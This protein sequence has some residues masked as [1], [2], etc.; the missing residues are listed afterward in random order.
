MTIAVC[1]FVT[2]F[3][4]LFT[5]RYFYRAFP[6]AAIDFKIT[7]QQSRDIAENFL[8]KMGVETAGYRHAVKFDYQADAKTFLERTLPADSAN[9]L[10]REQVRIWRWS[11]RWFKPL[12]KQESTVRVSPDG[13][14]NGF[15]FQIPEAAPGAAVSEDSARCVAEKFL[16][17]TMGTQPTGLDFLS[18]SSQ[19]RPN[20]VDH[21][22]EWKKKDFDVHG[23]TLR[24]SVSVWGARIGAFSRYLHVP[25]KWQRDYAKLRAK[26]ET[27]GHIS[28]FFL[29]LTLIAMLVFAVQYTRYG[30]I[31]WKTALGFGIV[32][33]VLTFLSYMND[34]PLE[35]YDFPTTE[36]LNSFIVR[37]VLL[38]LVFSLLAGFSIFLLTAAA[39]PVYRERYGRH[40]SLSRLFTWK[41]LRT[42][43][44]FL[45]VIVG[46]ALTFFFA[47]YQVGFYILT[48]RSGG[49]APQDIP[50]DNMLNTAFPWIYV[51]LAGFMPAVSE[52]FISRMFSIP[53][54]EKFLKSRWPAVVIPAMIWGFA[55]ANYP[56][57]PFYIRGLEVGLAG[58]LIGFVMIRFGIWAAL[59]WH[60]TVD[61]LYTSFVLFRSGNPY[62]IITAA[63]SC[64]LLLV[65]L[66]L[67]LVFY[68]R[69]KNFVSEKGLTNSSESRTQPLPETPP[70]RTGPDL[71]EY[72]PLSRKKT[73]LAVVLVLALCVPFFISFEKIGGFVKYPHSSK[74]AAAAADSLLGD[75]GY[76][77]SGFQRVTFTSERLN[78]FAAIYALKFKSIERFNRLFSEHC[79][80]FRWGVRYFKSLETEE[81]LVY[82][83]PRDLGLVSFVRRIREDVPGAH[84]SQDSALA[85]AARFA[86]GRGINVSGMV[87]KEASSEKR[88]ARTDYTFEWQAPK[89]DVRNIGDMTYR[90]RID[91]QGRDVSTFTT[92]PH[93][94]EEWQRDRQK[95][96]LLNTAHL[97]LLIL[98]VG[99]FF[100]FALLRFIGR[101]RAGQIDWKK[102]LLVVLVVAGLYVIDSLTQ[103]NLAL[104]NYPTSIDLYLYRIVVIIGILIS[105]IV[106]AVAA[107]MATGLVSAFY[108][109][110]LSFYK[111]TSRKIYGRDAVLAAVIGVAGFAGTSRLND[112]VSSLFPQHVLF[113]SLSVPSKIAVPFPWFSA[114]A[115]TVF[116]GV[117][118]AGLPAFLVFVFGKTRNIYR[119][120]F[121]G[122]ALVAFLPL[123]I[124]T[125][126]EAV[127]ALGLSLPMFLWT[128]FVVA[129][130]FRKNVLAYLLTP[131]LLNGVSYVHA[132]VTQGNPQLFYNGIGVSVALL[133]LLLW[134]CW[135]AF[136][137]RGKDGE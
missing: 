97:G 11:N 136:F 87:L 17:E 53:F 50:Y 35:L 126:G 48:K 106:V 7:R 129:V 124:R 16:A 29:F 13:F 82:I 34:L 81:Y 121:A 115:D 125:V 134:V 54:L 113:T 132:Y 41:G 46:L 86:A 73:V 96:S 23:A 60:Y 32:A 24:F 70:H 20:R 94:P 42:K 47:A 68:L 79:Q 120:L 109:H 122:V 128:L 57:Q 43:K 33:A 51:L 45:G 76:N 61:A 137:G 74:A 3:C 116:V 66:I 21:Y 2:L 118:V 69:H 117:F 19:T 15:S 108:P 100:V 40:L 107:G 133:G 44:V 110:S 12:Q 111:Y 58:I 22:F 26:N 98:T 83:D 18:S 52:E 30:D 104:R 95:R 25:E 14:L 31:K 102:I 78:E 119:F 80:S 103:F 90:V 77:V 9:Q 89:G 64:S 71:P 1:A 10:M 39:E 36:S 75:I 101:A 63:V 8:A 38:N 67:T 99:A 65:P 5:L 112:L 56:Q 72:K 4:L 28:A 123:N 91:L 105:T 55:H 92:F 49:W 135:P 37:Q 93:V 84:P 62:F 6:E 27:A 131:A 85:I 88:E 127:L 114:V 130:L 59:V